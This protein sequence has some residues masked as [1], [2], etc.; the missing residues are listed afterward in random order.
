MLVAVGSWRGSPGVT[1]AALALAET[2]PIP[3]K[4]YVAEC[5]PRGGTLVTRFLMPGPRRL[6]ELA[7]QARR[8]GD[9]GLLDLH[10]VP[11]PSGVRV[12][13]GP[14]D[15]RLLRAALKALL[16]PGGLF[17]Q[18]AGDRDTVLIADVGRVEVDVPETASLLLLADVLVLV[19]R[20][21]PEQILSLAGVGDQA[22][23]LHRDTGL[24]LIGPGYPAEHVSQLLRL[25]VLG[26]LP[27]IPAGAA[28][29]R[30]RLTRR[31]SFRDAAARVG[32][33]VMAWI[34]SEIPVPRPAPGVVEAVKDP[35]GITV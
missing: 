15:G 21:V 33:A 19:A 12:L 6:A 22:R 35:G 27:L 25:P 26:Q 9:L 28:A 3:A 31:D 10:A 11:V 5:D 7:G 14:E 4:V 16:V 20:P 34:A 24:L 2:W 30:G 17:E 32:H 18:A 29:V 23:R 1:T 8:G 13:T